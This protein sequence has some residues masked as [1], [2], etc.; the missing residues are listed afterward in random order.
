MAVSYFSG[1]YQSLTDAVVSFVLL[2][3]SDSWI[4]KRLTARRDMNTLI[5][6]LPLPTNNRNRVSEIFFQSGQEF[7]LSD[8][9]H[10][11][12]AAVLACNHNYSPGMI[13]EKLRG[14]DFFPL[15]G[16][17]HAPRDKPLTSY[18]LAGY[19][20]YYISSGKVRMPLTAELN[21][22]FFQPLL[23]NFPD[24]MLVKVYVTYSNV[25]WIGQLRGGEGLF[26]PNSIDYLTRFLCLDALH[27]N[28]EY[29][30]DMLGFA[31]PATLVR[32]IRD[33]LD[34]GSISFWGFMLTHSKTDQKGVGFRLDLTP[35]TDRYPILCDTLDLLIQ[36]AECG[37]VLEFDSPLYAF[38]ST[39][40]AGHLSILV[41]SYE[42]FLKLDTMLSARF[43][44]PNYKITPHSRRSGFTSRMVKLNIPVY[45]IKIL[46]RH[47]IGAIGR[48]IAM[49][50]EEKVKLQLQ[51][52]TRT[53]NPLRNHSN[54]EIEEIKRILVRIL[55]EL[56]PFSF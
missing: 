46:L 4:T 18:V 23:T 20:K 22:I 47:S 41:L 25:M 10:A 45:K 43:K 42:H 12:L 17:R 13:R 15:Q 53:R 16:G 34:S 14:V 1:Y 39:T 28:G 7:T 19:S 51:T 56:F 52:L 6:R 40:P 35:G 5:D 48:Y 2:S 27:I 8:R 33:N 44:D 37:E 11:H 29:I 31:Q 38:H 36:R 54:A 21:E 9:V 3:R 32:S 55:E 50:P 49:K 24:S 30:R 26:K